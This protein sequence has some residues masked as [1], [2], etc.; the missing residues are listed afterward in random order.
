MYCPWF[1]SSRATSD[2][3]LAS[4]LNVTAMKELMAW[5]MRFPGQVG[6][7]DYPGSSVWGTAER[8]KLYAKLGMRVIYFNGPRSDLLQW[9]NS[10]LVWD[11]FLDTEKLEAEYVRDFYGP[12]AEPMGKYLRLRRETVEEHGVHGRAIFY[13]RRAEPGAAASPYVYIARDLLRSAASEQIWRGRLSGDPKTGVRV[14]GGVLEGTQELLRM[15]HPVTG[16]EYG[17]LSVRQYKGDV[18]RYVWTS[19]ICVAAC[20]ALELKFLAR[21]HRTS[22][23][24]TMTAVGI[25]LPEAEDEELIDKTQAALDELLARS[26]PD[27]LPVGTGR[28]EPITVG[29]DEDDEAGK[30]L[31][32]GTQAQLISPVEMA[33]I[34]IPGGDDLRGVRIDA[35]L[36]RLPTIPKGNITIHAG[37]FFAERILDE[38][39][40]VTG[41]HFFDLHLHSSRD[42]PVTVYVDNLHSDMDLHAGEQIVRIDLRNFGET[43]QFDWRKWT[44][45]ERIGLDIWPQDNHYPFPG[46]RDTAVTL[47]GVTIGTKR[48]DPNALPHRR[49]VIWLSQFRPNIP[50][51]VAVPV[52]RYDEL[53]QRQHYK[54]VGLDYG[55][56]HLKEGFRTF[57][58]HHAVSPIYAIVTSSNAGRVER[59]TAEELQRLLAKITLVTLPINPPG[60]AAGPAVGNAI[61]LGES[62]KAAGLVTDMELDYV[63]PEGFVINAHNGRIAI[64]GSSPE[65]TARGVRRYLEDHGMRFYSPDEPQTRD[66]RRGL[67]HELYLPDRPFFEQRPVTQGEAPGKAD[68]AAAARL[69]E[70]IKDAARRGDKRVPR[71]VIAESGK[72][73][74]GRYVAAKLLWD[75]FADATRM[76]REYQRDHEA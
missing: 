13:G 45:V 57:T 54:H 41:R 76:I 47:L 40:D 34:A 33:T 75:P 62:A 37:R 38:P 68:V 36:S 11:P 64:T 6:M 67:L 58:E 28:V 73:A 17:R 7:Y 74:L 63:G 44:K 39:L 48:P 23:R 3:S 32:D 25:E 51:G 56:K 5:V 26:L 61:F 65:G 15:T 52:E 29:F 16:N 14:I 2:V 24:D 72:S 27:R 71:S 66:L 19:Q 69:A 4:P 8:V 1:W 22:F 42:V 46:A 43:E 20:E 21:Q 12:A 30:W 31:S 10:Q 9:I 53:M 70:A 35:P 49:K 18:R 50:R 59:A 60:I 55:W